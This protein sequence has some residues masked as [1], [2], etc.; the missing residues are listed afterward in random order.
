MQ[1]HDSHARHFLPI[2]GLLEVE[3]E[4]GCDAM[5]SVADILI[6]FW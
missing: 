3:P 5:D 4:L 1:L 6:R 2:L